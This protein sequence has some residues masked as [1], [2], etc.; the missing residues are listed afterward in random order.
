MRR[1][2]GAERQYVNSVREVEPRIQKAEKQDVNS[3]FTVGMFPSGSPGRW[4]EHV[5]LMD[6]LPRLAYQVNVTRVAT[7]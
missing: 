6:N 3:E 1:A 2:K 7:F 4:C 5:E